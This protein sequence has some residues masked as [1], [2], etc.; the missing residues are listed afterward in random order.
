MTTDGITFDF[1]QDLFMD[2]DLDLSTLGQ[3]TNDCN[4]QTTLPLH[5]SIPA[6]PQHPSSAPIARN[7]SR[8]SSTEITDKS[9]LDFSSSSSKSRVSPTQRAQKSIEKRAETKEERDRRLS[10]NKVTS[11]KWRDGQKNKL[12][13]LQEENDLLRERL[14]NV[15]ERYMKLQNQMLQMSQMK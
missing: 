13:T 11:K 15:E 2:F 1:N 9:S 12:N 5:S 4:D 10:R 8:R 3:I 14:V 7:I 6:T